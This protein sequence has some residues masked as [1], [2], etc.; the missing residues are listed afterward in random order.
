MSRSGK[1]GSWDQTVINYLRKCQI[2]FQSVCRSSHTHQ[3]CGSVPP[4]LTCGSAPPCL[5]CGSAPLA[6]HVGVLPLLDMWGCSP[7]LTCGSA[8]PCLTCGSA[9]PCLTSLPEC[10]TSWMS[11]LS[12]SDGTWNL[13][14]A[15]ICI[16][17]M[18]K[19]FKHFFKCFL[20]IWDSS[21]ENS[22]V[23]FPTVFKNWFTW[24]VGV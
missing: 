21:V 1:T 4:C 6:W 23:L 2:D 10:A 16:S 7:C 14:V 9:P 20:A 17:L 5:T 8:P 11:E 3:Q 24:V 22:L 12:H 19:N 15:L 18:N 13:T